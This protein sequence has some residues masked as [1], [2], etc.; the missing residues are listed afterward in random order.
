[1]A[2]VLRFM[3]YLSVAADANGKNFPVCRLWSPT[4]IFGPLTRKED[5]AKVCIVSSH[6]RS[7]C[8]SRPPV[9]VAWVGRD[10]V[11]RRR[12]R[13]PSQSAHWA[14]PC[15]PDRPGLLDSARL[16]CGWAFL[17]KTGND[18]ANVLACV[19]G[20]KKARH[21]GVD[22]MN[23]E[24]RRLQANQTHAATPSGLDGPAQYASVYDLA[25]IARTTFAREDFRRYAD[26]GG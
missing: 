22:A 19:G 23:D 5:I 21:G 8:A 6:T 18:A 20:G 24:A 16:A 25:L 9:E 15:S 17:L 7:T 10:S 13:R 26:E 3:I 14:H 2:S 4:V 1:M 11:R 12:W